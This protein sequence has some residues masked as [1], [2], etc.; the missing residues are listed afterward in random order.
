VEHI[1]LDPLPSPIFRYKTNKEGT[2]VLTF[3]EES[4]N[5]MVETIPE[6]EG[7]LEKCR[8]YYH[9]VLIGLELKI[10]GDV[11]TLVKLEVI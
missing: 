5:I 8:L 1:H 11:S 6:R 4:P 3:S 2:L 7:Y 9:D 10:Y